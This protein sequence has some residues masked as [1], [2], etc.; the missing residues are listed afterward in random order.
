MLI[1]LAIF[2]LLSKRDVQFIVFFMTGFFHDI[3]ALSFNEI[4]A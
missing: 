3:I 2:M 1:F 4:Y